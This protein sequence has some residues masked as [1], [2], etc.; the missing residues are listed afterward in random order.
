MFA[1]EVNR[2]CPER[3]ERRG[4]AQPTERAVA[5]GCCNC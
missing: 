1:V 5:V 4:R 3:D 2:Y